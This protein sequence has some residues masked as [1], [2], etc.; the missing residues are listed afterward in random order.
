MALLAGLTMAHLEEAAARMR[1][2]AGAAALVPTMR[3]N[4]AVTALVSGGFTIFVE[5]VA[6][7]LAFDR[8]FGNVLEV[9]AGRLT[10]HVL[11]P[12]LDATAKRNLLLDLADEY[13]LAA[14]NVIAVGDGANDLPMLEA[15]GLGVA[16][17]AKPAVR[18]AMLNSPTGAVI[19]Y[20]DL[21]ALLYLQ[22]LL[23]PDD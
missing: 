10:G 18:T 22:G 14:A 8:H 5:R 2:M 11:E 20:A 7:R 9:E 23:L 19:D 13:G 17:R 21:S 3:A 15:A 4:G 1:P 16:F 6:T 12:I